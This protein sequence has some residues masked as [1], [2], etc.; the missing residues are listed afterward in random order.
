MGP[1]H[2]RK[3]SPGSHDCV[4]IGLPSERSRYLK[5]KDERSDG[6]GQEIG[7]DVERCGLYVSPESAP[8]SQ[9]RSVLSILYIDNTAGYSF[10][11]VTVGIPLLGESDDSH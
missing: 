1:H 10:Q 7:G 11:S 4:P 6:D 8:C 5:G 2:D 9:S 3:L